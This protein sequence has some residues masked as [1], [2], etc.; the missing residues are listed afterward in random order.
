MRYTAVFPDG[1]EEILLSVPRYDLNWQRTYVLAEPRVI[2]SGTTI[3][4]DGVFDNSAMNPANPD[5]TKTVRFGEQSWD[6][7]F[8]GYVLYAEAEKK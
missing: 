5:P 3:R 6:E 4:V 1:K 2:P 8:I 7:M